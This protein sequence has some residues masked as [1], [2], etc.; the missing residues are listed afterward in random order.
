VSSRPSRGRLVTTY[1]KHKGLTDVTCFPLHALL[2]ALN[3]TTVDY[4][5]LDVE[6]G[7]LDVSRCSILLLFSAG[8]KGAGGPAFALDDLAF[9]N[10]PSSV[11]IRLRMHQ[12]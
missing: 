5:S 8:F 7:E 3:R 11:E 4:F 1:E 10:T 12:N 9:S 2:V 6:G